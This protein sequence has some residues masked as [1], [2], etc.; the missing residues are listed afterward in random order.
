MEFIEIHEALTINCAYPAVKVMQSADRVVVLF[1]HLSKMNV[2]LIDPALGQC[3][4][5][6]LHC[7]VILLLSINVYK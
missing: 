2:K 3:R 6:S 4:G 1:C 7:L 5:R